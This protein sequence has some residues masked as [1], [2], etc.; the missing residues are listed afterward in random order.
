[1]DAT[2]ANP[3]EAAHLLH[4]I[5]GRTRLLLV[6]GLLVAFILFLVFAWVTRDAMTALPFLRKQAEARRLAPGQVH[7]DLRPWQTAHAIASLAVT[8][9]EIEFASQA[10]R[11]ADHEVDQAFA[12]AL[13]QANLQQGKLTGEALHDG[14]VTGRGGA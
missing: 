6:A 7:V 9:E 10:Q 5:L 12:F 11:F 14:H 8:A 13:R 4:R 3:P 1:M 2:S